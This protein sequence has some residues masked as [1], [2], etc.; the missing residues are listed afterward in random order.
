MII[1]LIMWKHLWIMLPF[2]I[3]ICTL[4]AAIKMKLS[5]TGCHPIDGYAHKKSHAGRGLFMLHSTKKSV[6][7]KIYFAVLL[8]QC[9]VKN[10]ISIL[11]GFRTT[12]LSWREWQKQYLVSKF[13]HNVRLWLLQRFIRFWRSSRKTQVNMFHRK[14]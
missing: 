1:L 10:I 13:G 12:L 8:P 6:Q 3:V 9:N 5:L 7:N 14:L 4:K 11:C 2:S